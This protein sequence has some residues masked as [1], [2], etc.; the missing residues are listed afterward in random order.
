MW[1]QQALSVGLLF[2]FGGA[3]VTLFITQSLLFACAA[4][5][6]GSFLQ[7]LLFWPLTRAFGGGRLDFSLLATL[8]PNCWR[9]G[10]SRLSFAMLYYMPTL[11]IAQVL[12]V[13]AA[14]WYGF[15]IQLC[16]FI[17]ALSQLPMTAANPRLNELAAQGDLPTL[18][19]V[20]FQKMRYM[21]VLYAVLGVGLVCVG[22][23]L[24]AALHAKTQLLPWP[25]L[26]ALVLLFVFDNQRANHTI[27]V[28]AFNHFPFWKYDIASGLL[29]LSGAF[30]ALQLEGLGGFVLWL[31]LVQ[32]AW[33]FWWPIRQGLK[34]LGSAWPDYRRE[35]FAFK[36]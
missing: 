20:F 2:S 16:L 36:I 26:S 33:S 14:G 22:P 18:R 30:F 3:A 23:W 13:I 4:F 24:L 9:G 29:L 34:V 6:V 28:W 25:L 35:V 5:A 12:G 32:L 8:W 7:L 1:A 17:A 11:I 10:L 15:T 19:S 27:L 31:W 21:F